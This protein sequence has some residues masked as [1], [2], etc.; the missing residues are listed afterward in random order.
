MRMKQISIMIV[1]AFATCSIAGAPRVSKSVANGWIEDFKAAK[2]Q[3]AMEGKL[4]LMDFSGSDWCGWCR[5]MDEEV[6]ADK[7]FVKEASKKFVLTMI[8]SPRDKS[9]LS[10]LAEKQNNGLKETYGVRGFPTVVIVDPEGKEVA[11][12]SGYRAGGPSAYVEYLNELTSDIKWP[13]A[14]GVA[15]GRKRTSAIAYAFDEN[16]NSFFFSWGV[17]MGSLLQK[18]ANTDPDAVKRLTET[19][20]STNK[21]AIAKIAS[22]M[23]KMLAVRAASDAKLALTRFEKAVRSY[24]EG[25]VS[26]Y[27]KWPLKEWEVVGEM[28]STVNVSIAALE[29]VISKVVSEAARAVY[30]KRLNEFKVRREKLKNRYEEMRNKA[31]GM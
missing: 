6:F 8:D 3:A 11:R 17:P 15:K 29:D 12:H 26:G 9:I 10:S 21:K 4:I 22:E 23:N 2:T 24:H 19:K 5:K 30:E 31:L 27:G 28:E 1:G 18:A 14:T 7:R 25:Y 16:C 13:K 20:I